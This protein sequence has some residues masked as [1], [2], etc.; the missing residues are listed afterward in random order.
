MLRCVSP[1]A[2]PRSKQAVGQQQATHS[3]EHARVD[4][5]AQAVSPA[6]THYSDA[7][8]G[9]IGSAESSEASAVSDSRAAAAAFAEGEHGQHLDEEK[10]QSDMPSRSDT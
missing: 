7:E 1:A 6:G 8:S 9:T 2:P 4:L 5:T 3:Q 10:L